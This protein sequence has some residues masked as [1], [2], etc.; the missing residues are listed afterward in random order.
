MI[1]PLREDRRNCLFNGW[2]NSFKTVLA[3]FTAWS[4]LIII[5]MMIKGFPDTFSSKP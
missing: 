4:V 2:V 3:F 5:I 1:L